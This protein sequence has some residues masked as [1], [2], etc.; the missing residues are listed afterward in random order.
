MAIKDVTGTELL[1]HISFTWYPFSKLNDLVDA[2][3]D[4]SGDILKHD[5]PTH[6]TFLRQS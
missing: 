2:G 5:A 4:E 6:V 3:S 1:F